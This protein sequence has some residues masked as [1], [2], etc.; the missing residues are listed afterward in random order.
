MNLMGFVECFQSEKEYFERQG[1]ATCLSSFPA[2][3]EA[4]RFVG[5]LKWN[6]IVNYLG[7]GMVDF[8]RMKNL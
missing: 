3:V 5:R 8:N 2:A 4:H 6:C 1:I 7:L